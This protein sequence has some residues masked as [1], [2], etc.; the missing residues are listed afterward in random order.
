MLRGTRYL[1]QDDVVSILRAFEFPGA[2]ILFHLEYLPAFLLPLDRAGSEDDSQ[3]FVSGKIKHSACYELSPVFPAHTGH[4]QETP[5]LKTELMGA[6]SSAG[7]SA[8]PTREA[9]QT[10]GPS[11]QE[12]SPRPWQCHS[13]IVLYEYTKNLHQALSRCHHPVWGHQEA[14]A[15]VVVLSLHI[16][17]VGCGVGLGFASSHHPSP[18][19]TCN[20]QDQDGGVGGRGAAWGSR[21][22]ARSSSTHW[23][24]PRAV[25]AA[26]GTAGGPAGAASRRPRGSLGAEAAAGVSSCSQQVL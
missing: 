6:R 1:Q 4:G 13:L 7:G 12:M 15:E 11:I 16:G 19:V 2:A 23:L 10:V 8:W 24:R 22:P 26:G 20:G 9:A 3:R 21:S 5:S 18:G 25:S 17:H 14:P